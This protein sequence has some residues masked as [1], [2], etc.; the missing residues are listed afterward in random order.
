MQSHE[1][2]YEIIGDDMQVVEVELDPEETVI[3]EAGAMNWMDNGI[4][5]EAK[6]GDGT[7]L[8]KSILGKIFGAG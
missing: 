7:E 8:D 6:M 4:S 5:F 3:A 2:D 1:I